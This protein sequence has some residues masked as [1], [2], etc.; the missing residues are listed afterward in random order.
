MDAAA[1]AYTLT[2]LVAAALAPGVPP[3][4]MPGLAGDVVPE[5]VGSLDGAI[6][7]FFGFEVHL[8]RPEP[9]VDILI[10]VKAATGGRDRLARA[11]A[12]GAAPWWRDLGRFLADW[13]DPTTPWA[14]RVENIWL[15]FD[16]VAPQLPQPAPSL[17]F[18]A[19]RLLDASEPDA[20]ESLLDA[21]ATLRGGPFA[22]ATVALAR[23]ILRT[24]PPGAAVFQVGQMLARPGA[25]LRL[26]I[27]DIP[28]DTLAPYLAELGYTNGRPELVD[29]L[30]RLAGLG[31]VVEVDLDLAQTLGPRVG[32]EWVPP[33]APVAR[34][35]AEAGLF[36]LL[37]AEELCLPEKAAAC[38]GWLGLAHCR[39]HPDRWPA[40]L[41]A[42][43]GEWQRRATSCIA[44]YLHHVKIVSGPEG[45]RE[46]KAYLACLHRFVPDKAIKDM[47]R[48]G[49]G[50]MSG[51][52][53]H[54]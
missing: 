54:G 19:V 28:P 17:F 15:E 41:Y 30:G 51:A 48:I 21:S 20:L 52:A 44:R 38:R 1:P 26:C 13:G 39:R 49:A 35:G 46:A 45:Q 12:A 25:P 16:L 10:C 5:T 32:L 50:A 4:L 40:A 43:D 2:D 31:G 37:V 6:T 18:G 9:A 23:Q 42:G 7:D 24:L 47:L 14:A 33:T 8:R 36:D 11:V 29:L 34:L 3:A 22:P 27:R 53:A